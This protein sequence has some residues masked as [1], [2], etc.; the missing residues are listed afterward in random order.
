MPSCIVCKLIWYSATCVSETRLYLFRQCIL[1]HVDFLSIFIT[2]ILRDVL[3]HRAPFVFTILL[4][5]LTL[6][7]IQKLHLTQNVYLKYSLRRQ[8]AYSFHSIYNFV[9][10]TIQTSIQ[11]NYDNCK[12]Q[13]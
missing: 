7:L 1:M 2:Y 6:F 11:H 13:N 9:I 8:S 12:V 10:S 3:F 4:L 5:K